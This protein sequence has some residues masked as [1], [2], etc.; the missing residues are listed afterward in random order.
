M[1]SIL[2]GVGLLVAASA[3]SAAGSNQIMVTGTAAKGAAAYALDVVNSGDVTAFQV[4]VH[5]EGVS[6]KQ[7]D[8]KGCLSA[9]PKGFAGKCEY[10]GGRVVVA[11]FSAENKPLPAGVVSVGTIKVSGNVTAVTTSDVEMSNAKAEVVSQTAE[12]SAN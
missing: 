10:L 12:V 4:F 3:A 2:M 1:K 9:L 6:D 8:L 7:I 11:A 5:F